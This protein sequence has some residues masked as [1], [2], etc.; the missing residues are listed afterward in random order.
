ME[1]EL[2]PGL[3]RLNAGISRALKQ[4][5]KD[6]DLSQADLARMVGVNQSLISRVERMDCGNYSISTIFR[7][8]YKMNLDLE[9]HVV[10]RKIIPVDQPLA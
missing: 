3:A 4:F 5:R 10:E 1:T 7:I 9:L 2:E 8:L 6:A